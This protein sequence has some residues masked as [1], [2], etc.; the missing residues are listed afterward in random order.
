MATYEFNAFSVSGLA[1]QS[2]TT[3]KSR[4]AD[5]YVAVTHVRRVKLTVVMH[6]L[7]PWYST[8]FQRPISDQQWRFSCVSNADVPLDSLSIEPFACGSFFKATTRDFVPLFFLFSFL[9]FLSKIIP[10]KKTCICI[11]ISNKLWRLK[12]NQPDSN[13]QEK[14][15]K[16]KA[17][18]SS[19]DLLTYLSFIS[20]FPSLFLFPSFFLFFNG[21]FSLWF[22]SRRS[23]ALSKIQLFNKLSQIVM[24]KSNILIFIS[25]AMVCWMSFFIDFQKFVF[26][27]SEIPVGA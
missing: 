19:A 23:V 27:F 15:F 6:K 12:Q 9:A 25:H 20:E 1:E 22:I 10:K 21:E 4:T 16:I 24:T 26:K 11:K 5:Y 7:C 17:T 8:S 2:T 18:L 13:Q 3:G 14:S